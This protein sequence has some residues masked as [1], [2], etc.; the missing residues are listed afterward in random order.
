VGQPRASG[1]AFQFPADLADRPLLLPSRDSDIRAAFD[2]L[3]EQLGVRY[4]ILAEVDDMAMLRLLARDSQGIG[5]LPGIVVQDE[6]RGGLL[7]EYC[8]VPHLNE[9]FYAITVQRHF[10][11]PLL[12][13]LLKRSEADVLGATR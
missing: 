4:R 10:E 2:L 9:N 13:A 11:P 6:L 3:C 5:L 7:E 8:I 1:A 12:T